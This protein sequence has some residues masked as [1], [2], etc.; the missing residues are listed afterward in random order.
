MNRSISMSFIKLFHIVTMAA[1]SVV[2]STKDAMTV[3]RLVLNYPG[4][5]VQMQPNLVLEPNMLWIVML[6]FAPRLTIKAKSV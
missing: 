4:H 3:W 2:L 5:L 1:N 6:V